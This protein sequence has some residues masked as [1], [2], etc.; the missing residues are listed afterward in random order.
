M[1]A[2]RRRGS[3]R[4]RGRPPAAPHAPLPLTRAATAHPPLAPNQRT[5]LHDENDAA[6][7]A[8]VISALPRAEAQAV[9]YAAQQPFYQKAPFQVGCQA[10]GGKCGAGRGDEGGRSG[11]LIKLL[12]AP[13]PRR[14]STPMTACMA[15]LTAKFNKEVSRARFN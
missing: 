10:R 9:A 2:P 1:S 6:R 11:S 7:C 13:R 12:P 14:A 15:G 8:A 4:D 3:N 5:A